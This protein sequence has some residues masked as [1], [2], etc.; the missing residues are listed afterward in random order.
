MRARGLGTST[1]SRPRAE[2]RALDR[3]V[4]ASSRS[5]SN[6]TARDRKSTR[7]NSSHVRISYAVFCLKKK[8]AEGLV[9]ATVQGIERASRYA[10]TQLARPLSLL[11]QVGL[12]DAVIT[13]DLAAALAASC[14]ET[15][16]VVEISEAWRSPSAFFF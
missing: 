9:G 14:R 10:P 16:T 15:G 3:L 6:C 7:L 8:M 2:V 11:A 4:S 12:D 1:R 13:P 5:A